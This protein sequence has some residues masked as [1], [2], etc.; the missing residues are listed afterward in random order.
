MEKDI[1]EE[2]QERTERRYVAEGEMKAVFSRLGD[3]IAKDQGYEDLHGMDAVFRYLIDKYK[4]LPHQVRSLSIEDL[5]LLF[6]D[7]DSQK[8]KDSEG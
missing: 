6:D 5:S 8:K 7:Y 3:Q 2:Y 1:N 4:W